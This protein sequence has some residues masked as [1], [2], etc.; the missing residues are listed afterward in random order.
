MSL[1]SVFEEMLGSVVIPSVVTFTGGV[2]LIGTSVSAVIGMDQSSDLLGDFAAFGPFA[3]L[4]VAS[5]IMSVGGIAWWAKSNEKRFTEYKERL[6][7]HKERND[8]LVMK[9]IRRA[10]EDEARLS[11]Q[12]KIIRKLVAQVKHKESCSDDN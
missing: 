3:Q 1:G 2:C 5:L 10:D 12:D 7:D 11:E 8:E 4:F 6:R 9:I